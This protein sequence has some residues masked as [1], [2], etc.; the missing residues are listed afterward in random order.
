[1]ALEIGMNKAWPK[2]LRRIYANKTTTTREERELVISARTWFVLYLFEH[3]YVT[4]SI[5]LILILKYKNNRISYGVGRPAILRFD[6]SIRDCRLLL[7]HP[8]AI[9]DDMRL[10]SMVELMIIREKIHNRLAQQESITE[11]TFLTLREADSDFKVWFEHWD[12]KFA[13]KYSDVSHIAFCCFSLL[14]F[15]MCADLYFISLFSI[16]KVFKSNS[17]LRSFSTTQRRLWE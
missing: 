12:Q 15:F 5:F 7:Q 3:Q 8:L 16:D 10:V 6:E 17:S 4:P 9:E 1:M 2:I 11:E 14:S 13:E